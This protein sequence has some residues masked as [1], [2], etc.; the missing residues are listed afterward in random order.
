MRGSAGSHYDW[1]FRREA[2]ARKDLNWSVPD[3]CLY[4]EAFTG[5]ACAIPRCSFCLQD[6]HIVATCPRNPNRAVL[7]WLPEPLQWPPQ[8]PRSPTEGLMRGGAGRRTAATNTLALPASASTLPSSAPSSR[9]LGQGGDA[10]R[11][12]PHVR[13]QPTEGSVTDCSHVP[14]FD[15][16]LCMTVRCIVVK[17][18]CVYNCNVVGAYE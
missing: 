10:S 5:R 8:Q 15:Y 7:G 2:L 14:E 17:I 1:Q 3:A 11:D 13:F 9:P 12:R 18:M 16:E 4:N 6:D